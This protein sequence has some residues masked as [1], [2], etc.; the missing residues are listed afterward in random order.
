MDKKNGKNKFKAL[1]ILSLLLIGIAC[2]DKN[3]TEIK[4][5]G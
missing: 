1:I 2:K 4:T 3:Q 5:Q